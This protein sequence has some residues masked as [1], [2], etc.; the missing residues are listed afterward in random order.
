MFVQVADNSGLLDASLGKGFIVAGSSAGANLA[1]AVA[2][3]ARDDAFFK[4]RPHTG[5]L[6]EI[7]A[8]IHPM[9][10]PEKYKHRLIGALLFTD[11][12]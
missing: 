1:A 3:R 2:L 4:D 8:T 11:H 9:A 5:Q 6:L 12:F 7:P 10:Y